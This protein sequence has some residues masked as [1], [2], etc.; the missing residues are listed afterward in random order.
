VFSEEAG[1]ASG[2]EDQALRRHRLPHVRAAR[3]ISKPSAAIST[4]SLPSQL[5]A[6][7]LV[8]TGLKRVRLK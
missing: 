8:K 4:R 7:L 2:S 6:N 3:R 5:M 1:T